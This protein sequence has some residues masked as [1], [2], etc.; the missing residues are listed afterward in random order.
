MVTST[1]TSEEVTL[2][3]VE[4][5]LAFS[6]VVLLAVVLKKF[7]IIGEEDG[8]LFARLITHAIAP[9]VIFSQLATHPVTVRQFSLVLAMIVAGSVCLA[10]AWA[11]GRL[12]RLGRDKIGA[13]MITSSFGSSALL[14]YPIVQFAFSNNPEAMT[15]AILVSELGVA[16]PVFTLCPVIAMYFGQ[17]NRDLAAVRKAVLEYFRSPMFMALLLGLVASQVRP[18]TDSPIFAT[19]FEASQMILGALTVLACL[20]L[21]V[22]LSPKAFR[23]IVPMLIV[24]AAIQ[25]GLQPWLANVQATLYGLSAEQRQVLVLISSLPSAVLGPVFATRYQ[26]AGKTASSLAVA[27]IL[28]S[29]AIVPATFW[30]LIA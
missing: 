4:T 9:V 1:M 8:P 23:G 6:S 5:V 21:G 3:V 19:F 20:V 28:L 22:Q 17:A 7:K 25:M 16:L 18:P 24:S 29:V 26:C 11:A 14:G 10:A 15:D 12:M 27:N 2:H 13:L 30:I